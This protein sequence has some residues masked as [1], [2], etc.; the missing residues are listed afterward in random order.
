MKRRIE[1]AV[2]PRDAGKTLLAM[3][4]E[5]FTYRS[6]EEWQERIQRGELFV[7][8]LSATPETLLAAGDTVRY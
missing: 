1:S 2:A 8:D 5:R 7:N 3:L 4:A 6:P